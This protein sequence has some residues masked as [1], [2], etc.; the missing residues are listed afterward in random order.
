MHGSSRATIKR[1]LNLENGIRK[2]FQP[3]NAIPRPV[4]PPRPSPGP[5]GN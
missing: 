1:V 2:K 4:Y 5:Y 3:H